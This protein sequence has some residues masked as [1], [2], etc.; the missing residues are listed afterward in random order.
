MK[1]IAKNIAATI[2]EIGKDIGEIKQCLIATPKEDIQVAPITDTPEYQAI[3]QEKRDVV[4]EL[5]QHKAENKMVVNLL[6]VAL[7]K[8]CDRQIN[9]KFSFPH[10]SKID[11]YVLKELKNESLTLIAVQ[12]EKVTIANYPDEDLTL[13]GANGTAD[14]FIFKLPESQPNI[15]NISLPMVIIVDEE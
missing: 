15:E 10:I 13:D 11:P 2:I 7:A 12:P 9:V 6:S 5:A 1:K 4:A 8:C 3:L 14:I